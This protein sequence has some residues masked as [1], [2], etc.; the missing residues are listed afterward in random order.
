MEIDLRHI[1]TRWPRSAPAPYRPPQ[2]EQASP[3]A[4][5]RTADRVRYEDVRFVGGAG[6]SVLSGRLVDLSATGVSL[7]TAAAPRIGTQVH[8]DFQ[9]ASGRVEAVGEVRRVTR[10]GPLM[11][12]GIRFVRLDT[13]SAHAISAAIGR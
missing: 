4:E 13:A 11:R 1:V 7:Q 5:R 12:V 10:E 8:L 2:A 9:L 3:R 6:S